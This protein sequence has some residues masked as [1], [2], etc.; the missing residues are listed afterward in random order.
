[1]L[2]VLCVYG[3]KSYLSFL[4]AAF[5]PPG[6]TLSASEGS[7]SVFGW[8]VCHE[9]ARGIGWL[10]LPRRSLTEWFSGSVKLVI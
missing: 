7:R 4:N 9:G 6:V 3:G 8:C 2:S 5:R 1:M 10:V